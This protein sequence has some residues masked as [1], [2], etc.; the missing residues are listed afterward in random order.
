M[1]FRTVLDSVVLLYMACKEAL[2][3]EIKWKVC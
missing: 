3:S 2:L 1:Q